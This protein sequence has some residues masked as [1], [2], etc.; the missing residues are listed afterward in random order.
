L[1]A[2]YKRW[3]RSQNASS[4]VMIDIDHFKSIN[5]TY[6]YIIGDQVISHISGLIRHYVR[7]ADIC[8]RYGADEYMIILSDT[9]LKNAY[10]FADRLRKE[11]ADS[12]ISYNNID[13]KCTISIGI[14]EIDE[15]IVSDE[16]WIT[17]VDAALHRAKEG[18]RNKISLHPK[19]L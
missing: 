18:G 13:V 16:A 2:E 3:G 6:G 10:V 4:L 1:L 11:V 19:K 17:C 14:A 15:N 5:D 9:Q 7:E 8:G 12:L